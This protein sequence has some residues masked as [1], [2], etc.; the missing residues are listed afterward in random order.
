MYDKLK[1]QNVKLEKAK[2]TLGDD[3]FLKLKE[4]ESGVMLDY[5]LFGYFDLCRQ[6]N[7]ILF[8]EYY[9]LRFYER[10]NKFRFQLKKKLHNKNEMG[11][12]LLSCA[13]QKFNG[14]ELLRNHLQNGER[15]DFV[16]IDVVYEPTLDEKKTIFCFFA[17]HIHLAYHRGVEK[18]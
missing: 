4:V 2:E 5:T 14:Y 9:F 7:D 11:H 16:L 18:N 1:G 8:K 17:P 13:I 6:I 15:K 12:E 10:R 3:F